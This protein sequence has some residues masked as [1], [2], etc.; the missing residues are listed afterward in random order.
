MLQRGF[1]FR[2]GKS[3][4]KKKGGLLPPKGKGREEEEVN[5]DILWQLFKT[6]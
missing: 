5:G 4:K 1:S 6:F 2:R 3:A